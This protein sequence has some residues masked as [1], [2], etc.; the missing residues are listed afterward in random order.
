MESV[1]NLEDS[2]LL[3]EI[4]KRFNEKNALIKEMEFMTKKLL[5]M[6]KEAKENEKIKSEFLSLI[7]NEFNN[8]MSSILNI[9][10]MLINKRHVDRFDELVNLL[11]AEVSRLDFDL[12]NIFAATE[13]EAGEIANSYSKIDIKSI[14]EDAIKSF[15]YLLEDKNLEVVLENSCKESVVSDAW[16]LYLILLNLLSNACEYSF[17]SS[18]IFVFFECDDK[19][20]YIKVEDSGEGIDVNFEKEIF[21]R[22]SK[23]NSGKTRTHTGLGLGLSVAEGF[24]EALN[25]TIHFKTKFG[26]TEFIVTIPKANEEF[27]G[28]DFSSGANETLFDDFNDVLE[29]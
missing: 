22:F 26:K 23:Y 20:F 14:F 11:N 3:K 10:N 25:G 2:E 19:N 7:K 6:N 5:D 17:K 1:S 18:K 21:N 28:C 12:K 29:M 15:K 16:K 9:T 24:S 27:M 4:A 13:I 8:P